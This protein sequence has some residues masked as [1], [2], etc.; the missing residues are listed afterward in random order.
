MVVSRDRLHGTVV[1]LRHYS[2]LGTAQSERVPNSGLDGWCRRLP[3]WSHAKEKTDDIEAPDKQFIQYHY[4]GETDHDNY[5]EFQQDAHVPA[6]DVPADTKDN[7]L[8]EQVEGENGLVTVDQYFGVSIQV[9]CA[10]VQYKD[11][12]APAGNGICKLIQQ[13]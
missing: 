3:P 12:G 10:N 4:Q 5:Q 9:S 13:V 1:P 8:V 2:V 6:Y 11:N 7:R